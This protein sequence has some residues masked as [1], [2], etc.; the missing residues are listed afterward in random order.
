VPE[1]PEV[2]TL[3][4]DLEP[5][6]VGRTIAAVAVTG[7]RSVRRH[8]APADFVRRLEGREVTV[9]ARRGK[10]LLTS[11]DTGDV[12]VVH[13]GMSGQVLLAPDPDAPRPPHTHVTLTTEAGTQLR[14]VDPRT[15]G[16]VFVTSADVPELHN[17]GVDA[18]DLAVRQPFAALLA[19][20]RT[21]LKPLLMNQRVLAGLGNIYSDEIL[22]A[23][24]LRFD[25]RSDSLSAHE[26]R[27]LHGAL[28]DILADA[29]EH[30]G[31]SLADQQYRDLFGVVG[32]YQGRHQVYDRE[33]KPCPRCRAPIVR[34]KY[35]GRSHF[36][37]SHCQP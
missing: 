33:G 27:R 17:L 1:L 23:A 20:R 25:R 4:R 13:L 35:G 37:C 12:L 21:M 18:L 15:F 26:V 11:L 7:A 34:I 16:E 8:C 2:E 29:I 30:R 19:S 3:R 32:R 14:F 36:S 28:H 24:R 22:F 5:L 31:S 10:Y 6:L 9:V